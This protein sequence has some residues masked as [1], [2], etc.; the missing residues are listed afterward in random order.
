ME[1]QIPICPKCKKPTKRLKGL[2]I[3]TAVYYP[4][5]YDENG[6][7]INTDANYTT[8]EYIC[9]ECNTSYSATYQFGSM[10]KVQE[11]NT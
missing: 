1:F 8:T 3:T 10:V 4:P 6:V 11:D 7:N 9:L 5:I 2:S